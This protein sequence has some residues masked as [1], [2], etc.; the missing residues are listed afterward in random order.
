MKSF[1]PRVSVYVCAYVRVCNSVY[2]AIHRRARL[3]DWPRKFFVEV[4]FLRRALWSWLRDGGVWER[5][6]CSLKSC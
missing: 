3:R 6:H 4:L 2:I 5:C 1:W